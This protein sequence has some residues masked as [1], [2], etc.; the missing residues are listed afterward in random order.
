MKSALGISGLGGMVAALVTAGGPV[1]IC[2]VLLIVAS[3][4]LLCWVLSSAA[5]TERLVAII[6]ATRMT[7]RPQARRRRT[8]PRRG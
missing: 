8:R 7:R 1:A 5:R 4:G 6:E 3:G 2:A